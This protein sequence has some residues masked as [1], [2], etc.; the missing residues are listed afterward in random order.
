MM[1][2]N[3]TLNEYTYNEWLN[4]VGHENQIHNGS[5]KTN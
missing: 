5:N 1:K 4:R 2:Q 3:Q